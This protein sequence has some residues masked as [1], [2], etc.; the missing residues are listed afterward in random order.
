MQKLKIYSVYD[1]KALAYNQPFFYHQNGQAIRAFSDAVNDS[2]SPFFKH[3]A[4]FCLFYIGEWDDQKGIIIPTQNP[5]PLEE[6]LSV[7]TKEDK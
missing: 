4:D 6:A 1:K 2:Q 5:Q 7:K 3:P